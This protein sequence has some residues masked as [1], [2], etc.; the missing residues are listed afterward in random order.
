MS[1]PR[2]PLIAAAILLLAACDKH[3]SVLPTQPGPPSGAPTYVITI[4]APSTNIAAGSSMNLTITVKDQSNNPAPDATVININTNL[5]N[6]GLD[7]S[8]KPLQI[9][10]AKTAGGVAAVQFFAGSDQ[11]TANVLAQVGTNTGHL[12]LVITAA[13]VAPQANFTYTMSGLSVLF[14]DTSS[15]SP[16]SWTWNFGDN[17]TSTLQSPKHDYAQSGTYTVSLTVANG[18]GQ[19]SKSTFVTVSQ[20]GQLAAG[21][22]FEVNGLNVVFSDTSTGD[23]VSWQWDFGDGTTSSARNPTHSYLATG[24]YSVRL[25]VTGSSGA[26]DTIAHF[27]QLAGPPTALFDVQTSGLTAIFTDMSTGSP[28]AWSW[29]FGDCDVNPTTCTDHRQSTQHTYSASGTYS[30]TLG[31]SNAAGA[32]QKTEFVTV[33]L[34]TAPTANFKF[35][36]SGL[37]VAFIDQSTGATQWSWDF[38]DGSTST[39]QNTTHVYAAPGTYIVSLTVKNTAGQS[40]ISQLVTLTAVPV[41]NFDYNVNA[42]TVTFVDRS[43]NQPTAWAWDFGDGATSTAENP[44]HV[45]N[46]AGTYTVSLTASNTAG[47]NSTSKLLTIQ[48]MHA[49]FTSSVSGKTVQFTDLSSP[50]PSSWSWT[51]GDGGTSTQQNPKYTYAA[52]GTYTVTLTVKSQTLT[53]TASHTVTIP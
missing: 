8:G 47:S 28:T 51:F 50:P 13:P 22:T 42:A 1:R 14:S 12:N 43:T 7:S 31:V 23:P 19:S 53:G 20:R 41:A 39:Q 11:G 15:G 52:S 5:G 34:G 33:S 48:P 27:V 3:T 4:A 2:F 10:S 6:F 17:T 38:G 36:I 35:Q 37:T 24:S 40:S 46:A 49:D 18:G 30:V 29:N 26:T 9:T 21:F 45:Y 32:S 16:T 44:T 25:V